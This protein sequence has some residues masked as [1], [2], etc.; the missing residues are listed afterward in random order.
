MIRV[1]RPSQRSRSMTGTH[2]HGVCLRIPA[3]PTGNVEKCATWHTRVVARQR[4]FRHSFLLRSERKEVCHVAHPLIA[5]IG[6]VPVATFPSIKATRGAAR[7][8]WSPC[9]ARTDLPG[10]H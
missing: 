2:V 1:A 9:T 7:H 8:I 4:P 6:L 3:R 10:R 5:N